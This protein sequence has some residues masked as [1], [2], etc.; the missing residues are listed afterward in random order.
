M[1]LS[2]KLDAMPTISGDTPEPPFEA[3]MPDDDGPLEATDRRDYKARH[4]QAYKA[5]RRRV[6]LTLSPQE[7]RE[8]TTAAQAAGRSV[9][10]QI[11]QESCAYRS[12]R[13]L[14]P[15]SIEE[16]IRSLTVA[17]RRI[18][19]AVAATSQDRGLMGK[20]LGERKFL[21][22]VQAMEEQ[23]HAFIRRPWRDG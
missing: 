12:Q 7:Y 1:P 4:W 11:W 5:K 23:V 19:D 15:A 8:V 2:G 22:Q 10:Q 6:F 18:G 16:S 21:E 13:F 9:A 14:P 17:L 3:D 20:L